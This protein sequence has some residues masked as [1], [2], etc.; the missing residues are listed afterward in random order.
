[1]EEETGHNK[2]V[3]QDLALFCTGAL[4]YR[5]AFLVAM[6]RVL[7]SADS[8]HYIGVAKQFA[9][10]NFFDFFDEIP[11]L[12]P[13][14]G[15]LCHIFIKDFE[16]ACVTVSLI[17]SV[18]TIIPAYYLA[19]RMFG[20]KTARIASLIL[21]VWPWH[22]DYALR[23]GSE[24][25]ACLFWLLSVWLFAEGLRKGKWYLLASV[26]AFFALHLTRP[27]G[28]FFWF[29]APLGALILCIKAKEVEKRRLGLFLFLSTILIVLYGLYMIKVTGTFM[30]NPR[31]RLFFEFRSDANIPHALVP[32]ETSS[33]GSVFAEFAKSFIKLLTEVPVIM[34][35]PVL[36]IFAGVGLF[37]TSEKP[38]DLRLEL[39]VLYFAVIQWC[40]IVMGHSPAPRY[41]M[42][43][44]TALSIWSARGIVIVGKQGAA[45][46]KHKWLRWVPVTVMVLYMLFGTLVTVGSEYVGRRPRQPREYKVAG[47]WMKEN[48]EPG[49]IV[50]RKSIIGYYADM[51]SL[52]PAPNDTIEDVITRARKIDARYLVVDERYTTQMVP[53]LKPLLEQ[54]NVPP[55]LK[56]LKSFSLY[57]D[58]RIVIYKF[59]F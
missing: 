36:T 48:L 15:A 14:L 52:G 45:L 38:R 54:K 37:H 22:A 27:E 10:G 42:M 1:M 8:I 33:G 44:L 46:P 3:W 21:L 18:L 7:D 32:F 11:P 39:F 24:S 17:T 59:V 51:D 9:Q 12:Y 16:W 13:A 34:F 23:V 25:A 41:L 56:F 6:P 29:G 19:L 26:L 53:V 5:L 55:E 28:T 30:I 31:V 58:T 50:T 4:I 20:I 43:S 35:G 49:L 57:P 47:R 2:R 40:L